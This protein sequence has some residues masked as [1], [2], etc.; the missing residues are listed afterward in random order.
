MCFVWVSIDYSTLL[1]G[2]VRLFMQ[3]G[4]VGHPLVVEYWPLWYI[5]ISYTYSLRAE[6]RLRWLYDQYI[7]S[8][9]S[10]IH[11]TYAYPHHSHQSHSISSISHPSTYL[12]SQYQMYLLP[13]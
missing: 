6:D 13:F 2:F 4:G 1:V 5:L 3:V 12:H 11:S 7:I 8:I 10:I 9:I